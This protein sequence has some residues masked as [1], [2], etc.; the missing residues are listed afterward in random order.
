MSTRIE[1]SV[2]GRDPQA[3]LR[4]RQQIEAQ[5][6]R[7]SVVVNA[8]RR[9]PY[10][11][12]GRF[13]TAADLL[14]DQ[15]Y[16]R[17]RQSDLAQAIGPGVVRGLM[18]G[19]GARNRGN[20][21]ELEIEPGIGITPAGDLLNLDR[22]LRVRLDAIPDSASIDARLGVRLLATAAANNRSGLFVLALRPVEFT[23]NPVASYPTTL[24]GK[25]SVQD[26]DIIEASALTLIPYPDRSGTD[27]P[28]A[29]RARAAREIFAERQRAGALQD[30][31][32]LA[33]VCIE[34]GALRWLDVWMVRREVGAEDTLSAGLAPRPRALTEAWVRQQQDH[35]DDLDAAQ[36]ASGF[37]G[38]RH[39]EVLPPAGLLP[40]ASLQFQTVLGELALVQSFFP[41][42]VDCEFAFVPQD[43]IAVLVDESLGLPPIDLRSAPEELDHLPVLLLAPVPRA[44]LETFKRELETLT[45]PV[46][47]AAPGLVSRRSPLESLLR[48]NPLALRESADSDAKAR[49]WQAALRTAQSFAARSSRGAFWYVRRRQLP[50]AVS[51][52]G[53][54]LRLAGNARLLDSEVLTRLTRDGLADRFEALRARAPSLVAAE[55]VGLLAAPRLALGEVAPAEGDAPAPVRLLT[56]DLLRRSAFAELES[57]AASTRL[58][59]E[60]E[61]VLKI[62]NRYGAEDRGSGFDALRLAAGE[63]TREA[64]FSERVIATIATSGVAP[65]LDDAAARLPAASQAEFADSVARLASRGD[66]DGLRALVRTPLQPEPSPLLRPG[67]IPLRDPITPPD[68]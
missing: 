23:A 33:M 27:S 4:R 52:S 45:R 62:S 28:D 63:R 61:D 5:L 47:A 34:A 20:E 57:A 25:R 60:H 37:A 41:P 14:A 46:R 32:P 40:A 36:I 12:D 1:L 43:E 6:E 68:R 66:E 19:L 67:P 64:L 22:A 56:S 15:D 9:R 50:R 7:G 48:L 51:L 8:S 2:E 54:T 59:I 3:A 17:A 65:E 26:G 16:V 55:T 11:F 53:A 10:Y 58:G 49:A 38:A 18:V 35:L 13:L 44:Q 29:R 21:P 42:T 30:A 31:L 24:D 39:F